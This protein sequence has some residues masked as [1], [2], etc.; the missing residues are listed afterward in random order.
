VEFR[1]IGPN[2]VKTVK[3]PQWLAL[4]IAAAVAVVAIVVFV[5]AASAAL[6]L[7]PILALVGLVTGWWLRRKIIK[8]GGQW[9]PQPP[10]TRRPEDVID[11]DFEVIEPPRETMRDM[12]RPDQADR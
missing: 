6:V 8:E 1:Q 10:A 4:M 12:H 7:L 3:V 2:G 9:P 5:L 11:A